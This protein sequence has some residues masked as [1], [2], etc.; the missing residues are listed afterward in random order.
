[1]AE[2]DVAFSSPLPALRS[3][4]ALS[5]KR[6]VTARA[7]PLGDLTNRERAP[8]SHIKIVKSVADDSIQPSPPS[9]GRSAAHAAA[10][11]RIR[12]IRER[13][14]EAATAGVA[15]GPTLDTPASPSSTSPRTMHSFDASTT[16]L[17]ASSSPAPASTDACA[18]GAVTC[19]PARNLE[20]HVT[21]PCAAA[22]PDVDSMS[23]ADM[24]RELVAVGMQREAETAAAVAHIDASAAGTPSGVHIIGEGSTHGQLH[25]QEYAAADAPVWATTRAFRVT[26]GTAS[27]TDEPVAWMTQ[28]AAL[29]LTAPVG[30]VAVDSS[31]APTIRLILHIPDTL[32]RGTLAFCVPRSDVSAGVPTDS[33]APCVDALSTLKLLLSIRVND[34][35]SVASILGEHLQQQHDKEEGGAE[36]QAAIDAA[37]RG[38]CRVW[39]HASL[40]PAQSEAR[41]QVLLHM[42]KEHAGYDM[43]PPPAPLVQTRL[44]SSHVR[45]VTSAASAARRVMHSPAAGGSSLT[46]PRRASSQSRSTPLRHT[47]IALATPT[48]TRAAITFSM[49][50][51]PQRRRGT[52]TPHAHDT[53]FMAASPVTASPRALPRFVSAVDCT[54]AGHEPASYEAVHHKDAVAELQ[55][56]MD[57]MVAQRRAEE[58]HM[59]RVTRVKPV[60]ANHGGYNYVDVDRGLAVTPHEYETVY[61][62][63]VHY[64][65]QYVNAATLLA[66]EREVEDKIAATMSWSR[67]RLEAERMEYAAYK[68]ACVGWWD[69]PVERGLHALVL[70]HD[71]VQDDSSTCTLGGA[72]NV[73]I[74]RWV[75]DEL[76][77]RERAAAAVA[78]A[79]ET[80]DDARTDSPALG[81]SGREQLA[82]S[83]ASTTMIASQALAEVP[84]P[85]VAA[86]ATA[87]TNALQHALDA[88]LAQIGVPA[89][90]TND[91]SIDAD[92]A[93]QLWERIAEA[94]VEY[95]ALHR[96]HVSLPSQLEMHDVRQHMQSHVITGG[97]ALPEGAKDG[98]EFDL[99][100]NGELIMASSTSA[101]A[102]ASIPHILDEAIE[103][104]SHAST[105]STEEATRDGAAFDGFTMQMLEAHLDALAVQSATSSSNMDSEAILALL[106]AAAPAHTSGAGEAPACVE[107]VT[108]LLFAELGAGSVIIPAPARDDS[109]SVADDDEHT[110]SDVAPVATEGT[111]EAEA[112]VTE[113]DIIPI[114]ARFGPLSPKALRSSRVGHSASRIASAMKAERSTPAASPS[115]LARATA[116]LL[117]AESEDSVAD[118]DMFG[119]PVAA[120]A[121]PAAPALS[122][123]ELFAFEA[124]GT[125]ATTAPPMEVENDE[126][127]ESDMLGLFSTDGVEA[128]GVESPTR[129]GRP[130]IILRRARAL[131]LSPSMF[132]RVA[133]KSDAVAPTPRPAA[134][135]PAPPQQ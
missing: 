60:R 26:A 46:T 89:N 56:G 91:S 123:D 45:D 73:F 75:A 54:R 93:R 125:A 62:A 117:A 72:L 63:E 8:V 70:A 5:S 23:L 14:L 103:S 95:M 19:I 92:P 11:D 130:S 64:A 52:S 81:S 71:D 61:M 96:V 83:A 31:A 32:Q 86:I 131:G 55:I 106:Q 50:S 79:M 88:V 58:E 49:S 113:G 38:F 110:D 135:L 16:A 121:A 12:A 39:P 100:S 53:S 118:L 25:V 105:A 40:T 85:F 9:T 82:A 37:V 41:V 87:G 116:A 94:A 122:D 17:P 10:A 15:N 102:D 80:G 4:A 69:Q 2:N 36:A 68:Q 132:G 44:G 99:A 111:V 90:G 127:R 7:T 20:L 28:G 128:R 27:G 51:A 33:Y 109:P 1:M 112:T 114:P 74:S 35:D 34:V 98:T 101:P 13:A 77:A 133:A 29:A 107:D 57:S 115:F 129:G 42:I 18:P 97:A 78:A 43:T 76:L 59:R 119:A 24:I 84:F 47:P 126:E 22:L 65:M 3:S 67:E 120:A 104:F 48:R 6:G 134:E 30:E 124:A 21:L 108:A 66:W